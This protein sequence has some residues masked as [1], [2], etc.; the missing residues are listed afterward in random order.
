MLDQC[1]YSCSGFLCLEMMVVFVPLLLLLLSPWQFLHVCCVLALC[2]LHTNVMTLFVAAG[3]SS[4]C[5]LTASSE[6]KCVGE[7][8]SGQL[9]QGAVTDIQTSA[10]ITNLADIDLGTYASRCV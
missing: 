1:C 10:E 8:G 5:V 7:G 9:G 4:T 3:P 2:Y 6:I